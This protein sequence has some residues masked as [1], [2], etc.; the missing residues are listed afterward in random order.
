MNQG[1]IP[2]RYAKAL[3]I[4]AA[5]KGKDKEVYAAMSSLNSAFAGEEG[6]QKTLANPHVAADDK[7]ALVNSVA[8]KEAPELVSDMV[9]LLEHN[10]RMEFLREIALAY[11]EIYREEH[12]IYKVDITSAMALQPDERKRIQTLVNKHLPAGSTAEFSEE[13]NPGLI[14][15]FT[16]SIDNE[17][18]DVSVAADFKQ[19][20]LKLLSH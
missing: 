8:G 11:V 7:L 9:R 18:L 4:L 2:R 5:E 3:Y 1:L 19:L 14:G 16:V 20:R 12:H 17:L 10:H 13:V 15:G 6:L